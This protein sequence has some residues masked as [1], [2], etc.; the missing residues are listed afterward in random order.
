MASNNRNSADP[1]TVSAVDPR[2]ALSATLD[3]TIM[4]AESRNRSLAAQIKQLNLEIQANDDTIHASRLAQS[5]LDAGL[6]RA[7][8]AAFVEQN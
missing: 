2:T 1:I 4:T 5:E 8:E 6:A 3:E 7:R